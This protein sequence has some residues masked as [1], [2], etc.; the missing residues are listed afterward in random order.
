LIACRRR[1]KGFSAQAGTAQ[2]TSVAMSAT[3]AK[4]VGSNLVNR[5]CGIFGDLMTSGA[6]SCG[7]RPGTPPE[8][9]IAD[10]TH[11]L[12]LGHGLDGVAGLMAAHEFL[13]ELG[14]AL[15]R[16]AAVG[17]GHGSVSRCP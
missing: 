3:A 9:S 2:I 16:A 4:T 6:G 14:I 11:A 17:N 7:P 10:K 5:G 15:D 13:N 8:T 1:S 12:V